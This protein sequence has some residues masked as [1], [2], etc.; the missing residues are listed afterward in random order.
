ML[1]LLQ[2]PGQTNGSSQV[3]FFRSIWEAL[4]PDIQRQLEKEYNL[5]RLDLK[6]DANGRRR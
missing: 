6:R 5:D 2:K 1:S 3:T 4:D